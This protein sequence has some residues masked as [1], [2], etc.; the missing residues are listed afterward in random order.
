M[1]RST[2]YGLP[3][4][5]SSIHLSS[6]SSSSGVNARA[7]STPSP[8]ARLTAATTSRQWENAKIG[9]SIPNFSQTGV[10]T[11]CPPYQLPRQ[12]HGSPGPQFLTPRQVQSTVPGVTSQRST[13]F[14]T[15]TPEQIVEISGQHV[16]L[17]EA[18]DDDSAWIWVNMHH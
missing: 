13:D 4:M 2:P 12:P 9:N 17:M 6:I 7:P 5:L 11:C 10:R 8:P 14:T 3:S 16:A 15:P 1:T 18:S